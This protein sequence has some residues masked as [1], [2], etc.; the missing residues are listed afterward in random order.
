MERTELSLAVKPRP[1]TPSPLRPHIWTTWLPI[2]A[3]IE[4]AGCPGALLS[5]VAVDQRRRRVQ[6]MVEH[7]EPIGYDRV[8]RAVRTRAAMVA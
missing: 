2:D 6:V 1:P 5:I 4:V 3:T 8:A 7:D